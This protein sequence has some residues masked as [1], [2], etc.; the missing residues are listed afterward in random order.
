MTRTLGPGTSRPRS[1]PCAPPSTSSIHAATINRTRSDFYDREQYLDISNIYTSVDKSG[2]IRQHSK[3]LK[4]AF[5]RL[6]WFYLRS[7]RIR[8]FASRILRILNAA[9]Y[10]LNNFTLVILIALFNSWYVYIDECEVFWTDSILIQYSQTAR[11]PPLLLRQVI[12]LSQFGCFECGSNLS[13]F[14]PIWVWSP[15]YLSLISTLSHFIY[16]VSRFSLHCISV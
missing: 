12:H 14:H 8:L 1:A 3:P 16:T 13:R 6:W 7:A 9:E 2:Q 11:L 15:L 10:V 5:I 4:F